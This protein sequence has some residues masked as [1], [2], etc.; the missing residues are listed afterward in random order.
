M[1]RRRAL[2]ESRRQSS[3]FWLISAAIRRS[4]RWETVGKGAPALRLTPGQRVAGAVACVMGSWTFINAQT[5]IP[6]AWVAANVVAASKGWDPYPFILLNLFLSFQ[7]AYAA[8]VIMMSQNK[9]Q[10]IDRKAVENDSKS[11]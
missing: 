8:P 1:R 11:T 6:L 7:S 9:Q 10:D 5:V 3:R 2:A 4:I